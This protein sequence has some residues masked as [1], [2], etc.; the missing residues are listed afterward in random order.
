ML[1]RS[2]CLRLHYA[3]Y[4][5][6]MHN[7]THTCQPVLNGAKHKQCWFTLAMHQP[8]KINTRRKKKKPTLFPLLYISLILTARA[9]MQSTSI[10][11]HTW[12]KWKHFLL[13]HVFPR[14]A[15][16]SLKYSSVFSLAVFIA[17][18]Q[19][20]YTA[21]SD[22]VKKTGARDQSTL[23]MGSTMNIHACVRQQRSA[24]FIVTSSNKRRMRG[25]NPY[26]LRLCS[27][28]EEKRCSGCQCV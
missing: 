20:W 3:S 7:S 26:A 8:E 15:G 11:R 4:F 12:K 6:C 17:E 10:K 14:Y 1:K 2:G 27:F 5:T 16:Y 28:S 18:I 24:Y 22:P 19:Y 23:E 21:G 13:F 9:R 25:I